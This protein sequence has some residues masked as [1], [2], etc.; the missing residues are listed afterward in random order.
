MQRSDFDFDVI[1]GPSAPPLAAILPPRPAVPRPAD[2]RLPGAPQDR[3][4]D[5]A[6]HRPESRTP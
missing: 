5:P 1:G 6:A 3:S 4:L 2:A